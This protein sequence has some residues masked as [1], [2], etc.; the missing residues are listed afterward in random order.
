MVIWKGDDY[1]NAR[2]SALYRKQLVWVQGTLQNCP[3]YYWCFMHM[4]LVTEVWRGGSSSRITTEAA[5]M[6]PAGS[7]WWRKTRARGS[8]EP[9]VRTSCTVAW[10]EETYKTVRYHLP[11]HLWIQVFFKMIMNNE[12]NMEFLS[13]SLMFLISDMVIADLFLISVGK[14]IK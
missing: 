6:T 1:I 13:K 14:Y 10:R 12:L 8:R 2:K 4:L 11:R 7:W 5:V 3:I 9:P